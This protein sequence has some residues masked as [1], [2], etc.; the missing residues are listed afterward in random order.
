[1]FANIGAQGDSDSVGCRIVI[2]G[3]VKDEDTV[4]AYTVCLDKPG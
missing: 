4:N 3:A 2:D 1:V